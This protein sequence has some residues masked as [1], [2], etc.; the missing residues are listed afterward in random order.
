MF[1]RLARR[2]K[3]W[4]QEQNLIWFVEPPVLYDDEEEVTDVTKRRE[5]LEASE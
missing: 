4:L 2:F 5:D 1:S 3:L